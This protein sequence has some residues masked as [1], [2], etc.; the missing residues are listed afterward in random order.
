MIPRRRAGEGTVLGLRR[1]G[2]PGGALGNL[3]RG[4]AEETRWQPKWS[5][6]RLG[7]EGL[8]RPRAHGLLRRHGRPRAGIH[9]YR[10]GPRIIQ[11]R[12]GSPAGRSAGAGS[13]GAGGAAAVGGA[14][15]GWRG[16]LLLGAAPAP[17]AAALLLLGGLAGARAPGARAPARGCP[18]CAAGGGS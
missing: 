9:L 14:G 2:S 17:A 18:R 7:H 8:L 5:E 16:G 10:P 15:T 3:G 13:A 11:R 12:P 6:G 1:S 4:V